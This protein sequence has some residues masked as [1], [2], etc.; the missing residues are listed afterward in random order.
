M[1]GSESLDP[2]EPGDPSPHELGVYSVVCMCA[3]R[4]SIIY[5]SLCTYV[6]GGP[7]H[8]HMYEYCFCYII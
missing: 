1:S 5:L 2:K 4:T 7:K 6:Y 8:P 3:I